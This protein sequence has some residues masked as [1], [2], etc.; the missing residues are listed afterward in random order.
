MHYLNQRKYPH[1]P[2]PTNV[3]HGGVPPE[4]QTAAAAACGPCCLC[5]SVDILT[6]K[7]LGLE[8]CLA[9]SMENGANHVFGT[10]LTILAPV[11]AE[12]YGLSYSSTN[13][14]AEVIA[15]LQAGGTAVAL[16]QK[17]LF[18]NGRHYI[19]LTA[20][21]GTEP[22]W[23]SDAKGTTPV[24]ATSPDAK[25][26]KAKH[27]LAL[28]ITDCVAKDGTALDLDLEMHIVYPVNPESPVPVMM[29]SGS[30]FMVRFASFI[31]AVAEQY[32]SKHPRLPHPHARPSES[33]VI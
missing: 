21:D 16:I 33:M 27:T 25:Y 22:Q 11:V 1:I 9:L 32:A 30:S 19:L 12:K 20:F 14:L 28:D 31:I 3:S 4:K 10:D 2:Y 18:A 23:Y 13:D 24:S 29:L 7:S 8:E 17:G 26:I 15:H 5:M 6:D